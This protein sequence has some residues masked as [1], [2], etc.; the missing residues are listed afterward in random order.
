MISSLILVAAFFLLLS[1]DAVSASPLDTSDF[2]CG[3]WTLAA[4]DPDAGE[5]GAAFEYT[6]G[7]NGGSVSDNMPTS[8][9][10]TVITRSACESW[11]ATAHPIVAGA[12][13]CCELGLSA[14][15]DHCSWSDGE[16]EPTDNESAHRS[17][18]VLISCAS[19]L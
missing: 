9:S 1:S 6:C 2:L 10:G 18:S 16:A 8:R 12:N 14:D 13:S 15:G 4:G 19:T 5:F 3:Q 11:C 7:V 17:T